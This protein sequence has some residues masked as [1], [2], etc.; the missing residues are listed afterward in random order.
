[1]GISAKAALRIWKLSQRGF[2]D[3]RRRIRQLGICQMGKTIWLVGLPELRCRRV[4][5][6]VQML[7]STEP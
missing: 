4:T 7:V 1:M 5:E 2:V 6:S 3:E